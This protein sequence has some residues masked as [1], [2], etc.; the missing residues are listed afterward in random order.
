MNRSLKLSIWLALALGTSQAVAL[1]L[2][3]IQI[4][5]ALGQPL[6][7]EI[8]V[9]PANPA[10]L[11]NLSARLA[12]NDEFTR[13]GITDGR[14]NI[15]LQFSI[16]DEN[17]H[18]VIRI[19][20]SEAVNNPYLDLLVEVSS[21]AGSSVRE[22]TILLDPPS[23][24]LAQAPVS[25]APTTR[26]ASRSSM[27]AASTTTAATPRRASVASTPRPAPAQAAVKNGEYGP[28]T[29][30]Q[31]LSVVAR[32]TAPEGVD[33]NQMML[34]LK[35]ANPDAFYRD[36][37]NAL[38]AGAV[39]RVPSREDAQTVAIAAAAAAVRQQNGDW[40][41]GAARSA[42]SVA[43]AGTR[44]GASTAP[45]SRDNSGDRL[46]LV[47]AKEG[48]QGEAGSG[49]DK[50]AAGIRQELQRSQETLTSLQ[51]QGADLKSRLKDL[52][53]INGKNE[54]LLSLKDN[55][56]AELQQ[57]LATARKTAGLPTEPAASPSAAPANTAS[58]VAAPLV[59]AAAAAAKSAST[60]AAASTAATKAA[61][62]PAGS[63]A[64]AAPAA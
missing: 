56:I 48:A 37:I 8:P 60:V 64:A 46:A 53:D 17:G 11:Q 1:D 13:A 24:G 15:P 42:T 38:K 12:S 20:S 10:E 25:S 26:R 57:K 49:S 58:N 50:S 59:A 7:A 30:G 62:A 2:G 44:S 39:L 28:V 18:K 21:S 6:L 29:Q 32:A 16:A 19:T 54:R 34:A 36:N 47:P 43:D 4:K 45:T 55:E 3:Q 41:S 52:E 33:T 27:P 51:Q 23:N 40:R 22:F 31:N 5:S 9:T 63:A 61:A 35:A 14:P